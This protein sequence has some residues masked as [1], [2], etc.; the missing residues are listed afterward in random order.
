[1]SRTQRGT[2]GQKVRHL[3]VGLS[4]LIHR[5]FCPPGRKWKHINKKQDSEFEIPL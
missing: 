4:D 3:P 1:M 2:R 5:C